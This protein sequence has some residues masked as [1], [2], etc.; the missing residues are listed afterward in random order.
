MGDPDT[1]DALASVT[2]VLRDERALS[3]RPNEL[4][5]PIS[6]ALLL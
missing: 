3:R 1:S 5:S 4:S 6:R 2:H